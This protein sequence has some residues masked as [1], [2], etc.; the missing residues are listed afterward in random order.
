MKKFLKWLLISLASILVLAIV[1]VS[2]ALSPKVLT[3]IVNKTIAGYVDGSATVGRARLALLRSFPDATL[4][5]DSLLVTYPHERFAQYDTVGID[6]PLLA[7]GRGAEMDTLASIGRLSARADYVQFLSKKVIRA[8]DINIRDVR[9]Y[10]HVY[11]DSTANWSIFHFPSSDDTTSTPL[12]RITAQSIHVNGIPAAVFTS[13]KDTMFLGVWCDD[14]D[15]KGDVGL[16]D[17]DFS[18]LADV[19]LDGRVH[20]QCAGLDRIEA[21]AR[22][23]GRASVDIADAVDIGIE[24]IKALVDCLPLEGSGRL[25]FASDSTYVGAQARIDEAPVGEL[26]E[27]YG[28]RFVPLLRDLRT[29]ALLT[30]DASADGWFG[31][32]TGLWPL[33]RADVSVPPSHIS[34][35]GLVDDGQFDLTLGASNTEQGAVHADLEDLCFAIEGISLNASGQGDD[36]LGKDPAFDVSATANAEFAKV[37]SYLPPSLGIK[38]DG[39]LDLDVAGQFKL[40]QLTPQDIHRTKLAAHLTSGGMRVSIPADTLLAYASATDL[41]LRTTGASAALKASLDSLRLVGGA[42]TYMMGRKLNASA[43]TRGRLL[44]RAGEVQPLEA[45]VSAQSF[46]MLSS[47]DLTL[48]I[49][50]S[51][52]DIEVANA[53]QAGTYLPK[54]SVNSANGAAF[55]RTGGNRVNLSDAQ[56]AA[57]AQKRSKEEADS[58]QARRRPA[59]G[60][61]R[62]DRAV[63]DTARLEMMIPDYLRELD[64]RKKDLRIDVGEGLTTL[65]RSWNPVA[66][67][68]VSRG[69]V[70][71]P[72]LPLRNSIRGLEGEFNE[73]QIIIRS[74]RAVSGESDVAVDGRLHGIK[75]LLSGRRAPQLALV[76]HINSKMLNLNE[77]LGA[78]AVGSAEDTTTVVEGLADTEQTLDYSLIVV[79]GNLSANVSVNVD[80]VRYSKLAFGDFTSRIRM[81]QRTLQLTNTAATSPFGNATV[82]GFYSTQS[83]QDISAGFNVKLGDITADRIIELVPAVDSLV[84]MLKSFKGLLNAELAATTQLDTNMNILIPTING[85]VKI[86]GSGLELSDTGDLRRIARILMFKDT[87]VGHIDDM[88]VNGIISDN[89]LEVYPFI[90]GVDRYTLGLSG[91]QEFDQ[92]FNYHISVIKSPLPFKFGVNLKGTFDDWSFRLGRAKYKTTSIPLFSPQVDTMQVNLAASIKDIFNKGAEQAIREYAL[93]RQR[94]GNRRAEFGLYTQEAEEEEDDELTDDEMKQLDDYMLDAECEAQSQAIEEELDNILSGDINDIISGLLAD[95]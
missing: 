5:L 92:H 43:Q 34:Y 89:R 55:L 50:D 60:R 62:T 37:A 51:F 95:L 32:V 79:P 22:I 84:P 52:N 90:L 49:R 57:S 94:L 65:F 7:E 27:S 21:P 47:D 6:S 4:Q 69:T 1:A 9:S 93:D 41:S 28:V 35:V 56:V 87:K 11:D 68:K 39:N 8:R 25:I 86:G 45:Q 24:S 61:P 72:L 75:P 26:V 40:S 20:F 88:S 77:I 14:F 12:P 76:L 46:N 30:L 64:F 16:D 81:R 44:S 29:D 78:L 80:S 85:A 58:L 31:S 42:S 91:M 53:S 33:M 82:E 71:T 70:G 83:K 66:N 17:G 23:E 38:A 73:N 19:L 18:T 10:A 48:G 2:V 36:I 3:R 54:F 74:L 13:P 67:V 63:P 59:G 15:I